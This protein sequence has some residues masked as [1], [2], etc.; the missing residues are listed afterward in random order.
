MDFACKRPVYYLV[1]IFTLI[2]SV[3][4]ISSSSPCGAHDD[5]LLFIDRPTIE[6]NVCVAPYKAIVLETGYQ[7]QKLLNQ[8]TEQNLPEALLRIG[9]ANRFEFSVL[10]PNYIHQ[11]IFPHHGLSATSLGI[12]HEIATGEKW[13]T[14]M[15]GFVILPS[16]SAAFGSRKTGATVNSLFGYNLTAEFNLSGMLGVSSQSQPIDSGGHSYW[17]VNPD[18][19]LSWSTNKI[20][21]FAEIYG[22]SKTG[23]HEGSGFNSDAGILYLIRKNIAIDLEVGHRISGTLGGF[24]RYIGTGISIQFA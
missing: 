12:K 14:S 13:V 16:G 10:M 15:E 11:T 24:D 23:P 21:L 9:L 7:Y 2:H 3:I 4:A 5:L 8:G 20:S 6:D 1:L 17:T 19:V 18:L 22:Q